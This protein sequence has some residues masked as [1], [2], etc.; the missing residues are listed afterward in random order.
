LQIS[1]T[2]LLINSIE[3]ELHSC[4]SG[5]TPELDHAL[6]MYYENETDDL[7]VNIVRACQCKVKEARELMKQGVFAGQAITSV[8]EPFEKSYQPEDIYLYEEPQVID[9]PEDVMKEIYS[10]IR[11]FYTFESEMDKNYTLVHAVCD[12]F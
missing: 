6:H 3:R 2:D 1:L 8:M 12:V 9:I 10:T 11:E 7:E 4:G 5:V